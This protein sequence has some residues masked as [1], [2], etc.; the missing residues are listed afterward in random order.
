MGNNIWPSLYSLS[1]LIDLRLFIVIPLGRVLICFCEYNVML[2][3]RPC[4]ECYI[5]S[6]CAYSSPK[7]LQNLNSKHIWF[8]DFQKGGYRHV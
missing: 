1:K 4:Q 3:Y 5:H 6:I 2:D 7:Y 8:H